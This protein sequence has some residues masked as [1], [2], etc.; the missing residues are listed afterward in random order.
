M[1]EED[2]DDYLEEYSV[3]EPFGVG[4]KA[5]KLREE[6]V[7]DELLKECVEKYIVSEVSKGYFITH[8]DIE[9]H[10][11]VINEHGIEAYLQKRLELLG[12][13]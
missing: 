10:Q 12:D 3:K 8:E 2:W 13:E 9:K 7:D 1:I 4:V 5:I 6:D 11:E